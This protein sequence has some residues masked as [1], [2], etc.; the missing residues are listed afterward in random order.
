MG[1]DNQGDFDDIER[2]TVIFDQSPYSI[3][4]QTGQGVQFNQQGQQRRKAGRK[5]HCRQKPEN[6]GIGC[7]VDGYLPQQQYGKPVSKVLQS[8]Q[9]L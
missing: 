1:T 2:T 5:Y 3:A 4:N 9:G 6:S 7:P 8:L